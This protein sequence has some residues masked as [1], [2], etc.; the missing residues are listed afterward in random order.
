MKKPHILAQYR[1][2]FYPFLGAPCC[3]QMSAWFSE[4]IFQN[5]PS[6]LLS[7]SPSQVYLLLIMGRISQKQAPVLQQIY[8]KLLVPTRVIHLKGCDQ[9]LAPYAC[10]KEVSSLVHVDHVI[11]GCPIL[12]EKLEEVVHDLS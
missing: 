6:I 2:P 5:I 10:L 12:P 3:H 4:G 11:D 7:Q 8:E 9:N 1:H